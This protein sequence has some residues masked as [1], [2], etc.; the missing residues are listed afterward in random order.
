MLID[1]YIY[2]E[3]VFEK[4]TLGRS[5]GDYH[6]GGRRGGRGGRGGHGRGFGRGRYFNGESSGNDFDQ[7]DGDMNQ[8]GRGRGRH[9]AGLTGREIGLWY[10]RNGQKNKER[11][12]FNHVIFIPLTFS[13]YIRTHIELRPYHMTMVS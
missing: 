2:D 1:F 3:T 8:R 12:E 10:A 6:R 9:P 7:A 4:I 13:N 5:S 11:N